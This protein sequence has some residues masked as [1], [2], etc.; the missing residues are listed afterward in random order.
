MGQEGPR[1]RLYLSSSGLGD[2]PQRLAQLFE[3]GRRVGYIPNAVDGADVDP[4]WRRRHI[5]EDLASLQALGL[6]TEVLD[7]KE[8]F[9]D[10]EA[11]QARL[12]SLD[13]I[14]LSGGNTF[15]LVQ[16]LNLSGLDQWL[17]RV[18]HAFVYGGYGAAA[19][20]LA[21]DLRCYAIVDNPDELPYPQIRSPLWEGAGLLDFAFI[22]HYDSEHGESN[23]VDDEIRYCIENKILFQAFRDGEVFI[24]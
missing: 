17:Q 7:L 20:A 6:N 12:Q 22:P 13:G 9:A 2:D 8:Y 3:Q 10:H 24:R 5:A 14:F 15:V 21:K 18:E 4:E 19:C 11:L 1:M 16:A 23:L